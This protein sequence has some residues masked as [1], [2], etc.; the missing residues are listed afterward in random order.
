MPRRPM[1]IAQALEWAFATEKAQLD[2]AEAKGDNAR[3]G[4]STLWTIMQRGHLG[5]SVDGGGR[6]LPH[7]D[8]DMIA[9]AVA[10]LP[11]V[12]GGRAMALLVAECAR[13]GSVPDWRTP[14]PAI[15]PVAWKGENQ[16]GRQAQAEVVDLL[17]FTRRG[18]K[19]EVPVLACPVRVTVSPGRVQAVRDRYSAW[20]LALAWLAGDLCRK[21]LSE[22]RIVAGLP[23]AEPWAAE[24]GQRAA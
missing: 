20:R 21:P 2:F 14:P 17:T 11:A 8:A 1:T 6:S 10:H 12:A 7:T 24:Q 13:A 3:P 15:V 22:V 23:V 18:R 16:N 5:C 4:V 19:I 9:S